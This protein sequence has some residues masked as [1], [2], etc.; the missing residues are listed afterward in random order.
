M[1][2][3]SGSGLRGGDGSRRGQ[4]CN[5]S[6]LG[7]A[8]LLTSDRVCAMVVH[9]LGEGGFSRR[10]QVSNSSF[11]RSFAFAC[12]CKCHSPSRKPS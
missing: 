8:A 9:I 12:L 1:C 4:T 3:Q 7:L 2:A 11:N 10:L 6:L 5:L